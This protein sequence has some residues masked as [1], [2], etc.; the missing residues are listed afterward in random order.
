MYNPE[1]IGDNQESRH[2]SQYHHHANPG[3]LGSCEQIDCD[4]T[5]SK[6]SPPLLENWQQMTV[7]PFAFKFTGLHACLA[8]TEWLMFWGFH[9]SGSSIGQV[10]N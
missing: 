4:N 6:F 1:D 7:S 3:R 10:G 8:L 5:D 2:Q 9:W